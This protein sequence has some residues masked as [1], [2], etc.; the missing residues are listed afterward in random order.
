MWA[1]RFPLLNRCP[2]C[3]QLLQWLPLARAT[4][5]CPPVRESGC[6]PGSRRVPAPA[7]SF[8]TPGLTDELPEWA[9]FPD[10]VLF[11]VTG[12]P[13]KLV[14]AVFRWD[15]PL[16]LHPSPAP[17]YDST[18]GP[19]K[20]HGSHIPGEFSSVSPRFRCGKRILDQYPLSGA[21]YPGQPHYS[22]QGDWRL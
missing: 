6:R 20:G 16:W 10:L 8:F 15:G 17:G 3:G 14:V 18:V 19:G 4:A 2:Q 12:I 1:S 7:V 21:V 5:W 11:P 13:P 22:P 9:V